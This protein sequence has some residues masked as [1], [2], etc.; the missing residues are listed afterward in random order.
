MKKLFRFILS[1]SLCIMLFGCSKKVNDKDIVIINTTDVHCAISTDEE[2]NRLGYTKVMAYKNELKEDNYVSLV[3]SGDYLQGD[4]VG[5][6]SKGKY[7]IDVMNYVEYDVAALGNHEFDYGIDELVNRIDEFNGDIVSCNFSYIGN[8]ENKF[9]KVKPYSLKKYGK[10]TIGYVGITTPETLVSSNPIN[11]KEDGEVA[12][13]FKGETAEGY[14]NCIQ[15]NINKCKKD[16]ADY[17]VLLCH[18]GTNEENIPFMSTDIIK[19]TTGYV[20]VLDGHA[21]KDVSWT[22][23]KDKKNKDVYLCE[24]GTKLNEF[25]TLTITKNGEIKTNFVTEYDKTDAECDEYINTLNKAVDHLRN[26]VLTNIDISLSITDSDGVRMV[27]SRETQIGN[28]IA[29]AYRIMMNADIAFINGGGIRDNLNAGDVT[30]GDIQAVHP[31]GNNVVTKKVLGSEI[32]DYLE[33]ASRS[34]QEKYKD[35]EGN[36]VGES[37]SFANVSGLKYSIKVSLP[38]A[39]VTDIN[40]NFVEVKGKRRAFRVKVLSNGEYVDIDPDKY[41]T[42]ASND[43]ILI[44]GGDGVNM[45]V[46]EEIVPNAQYFDY[47]V[48]I[49]YIVDVLHGQLADKY[50]DIEGRIII[51]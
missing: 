18:A 10:F 32:L 14:Y 20:A 5:A 35:S 27:R 40:G 2:K 47:E 12:Y 8:K 21:H 9:T 41:Y 49:N 23:F 34:T 43:Y 29:D 6:I 46:N 51:E 15:E 16:G 22:T 45:F 36:A 26:V 11:F 17:V 24:C 42:V 39:V 50:N 38:S 30:Y 48:V 28:L 4:L 13:S 3:D 44:S 33:F 1:I 31:F 37:G 25:S 19:N 7:I